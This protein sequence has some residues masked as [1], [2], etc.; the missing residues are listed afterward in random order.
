MIDSPWDRTPELRYR[1]VTASRAGVRRNAM[2]PGRAVPGSSGS[3]DV[4][5]IRA[6]RAATRGTAN[7]RRSRRFLTA[8]QGDEPAFSSSVER[9]G[10]AGP[11]RG[12]RG[13]GPAGRRMTGRGVPAGFGRSG[14]DGQRTG[15]ARAEVSKRGASPF[16]SMLQ[17]VI[18]R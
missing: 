8:D 14:P 4:P 17:W 18:R 11:D 1:Q 7:R 10:S 2:L 6:V 16:R 13:T 15:A 9:T 3:V 5:V 12:A